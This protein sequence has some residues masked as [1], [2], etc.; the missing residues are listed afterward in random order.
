MNFSDYREMLDQAERRLPTSELPRNKD[1]FRK[2]LQ[3]RRADEKEQDL[4]G[5]SL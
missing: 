4:C 3:E 5:K 1:D 2:Q